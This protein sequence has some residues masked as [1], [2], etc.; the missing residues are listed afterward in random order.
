MDEKLIS[1]N[2]EALKTEG[3]MNVRYPS[4]LRPSVLAFQRAC[5]RFYA[6]PLEIK[7]SFP[8]EH[9]DAQS[10]TGYE[11]KDNANQEGVSP[12]TRD[13]K[14]NIHLKP[15]YL[16][17]LRDAASKIGDPAVIDLI[18]EYATF[19]GLLN[20]WVRTIATAIEEQHRLPGLADDV[21]ANDDLWV[22]RTLHY[23]G[24]R[25]E[26]DR[27]ASAHTDKCCFTPHLFESDDGLER[28]T[29]ENEWVPMPVG[30]GETAIIPGM[31]LQ[32]ISQNDLKA[33]WHRVMANERTAAEGR[34]SMVCFVTA[35][36]R[37][38]IDS[39][40]V[41]RMQDLG[42][43]GTYRMPYEDVKNLFKNVA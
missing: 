42:I 32:N 15:R 2:I 5:E 38:I 10:G 43:G 33:T 26:H 19:A 14:E 39:D 11:Y 40:K 41:G 6:L 24:E 9:H 1:S 30:E 25:G 31:Q 18:E 12:E 16:P 37:P 13:L 34:Y 21:M 29:Y 36:N 4:S 23:F 3:V 20:P 8:Y 22:L 27:F 35:A 28:L 7:K 17:W